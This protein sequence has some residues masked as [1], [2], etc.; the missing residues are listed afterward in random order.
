MLR[1]LC[2][3]A[4]LLREGIVAS[5]LSL[6]IG[7]AAQQEAAWNLSLSLILCRRGRTCCADLASVHDFALAT[8][9][10]RVCPHACIKVCILRQSYLLPTQGPQAYCCENEDRRS[11][12][13]GSSKSVWAG[14]SFSC[15]YLLAE[16]VDYK[17]SSN[18]AEV[19][20]FDVTT[21]KQIR[22][23]SRP[24]EFETA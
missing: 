16:L 15:V 22:R 17:R 23:G 3:L 14:T 1:S 5:P 18:D 24:Q 2:V 11:R 12:G 10:G 21:C 8:E 7:Q 13:V 6:Y 19:N 9:T 4:E 20:L